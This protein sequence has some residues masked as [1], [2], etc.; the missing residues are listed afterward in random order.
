MAA[1]GVRGDSPITP[2]RPYMGTFRAAPA[3]ASGGP[4]GGGGGLVSTINNL[5]AQRRALGAGCAAAS[6]L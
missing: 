2:A 4:M 1:L 5:R 6:L 3:A